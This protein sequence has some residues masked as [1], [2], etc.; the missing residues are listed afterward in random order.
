MKEN[1][2]L[3]ITLTK[4]KQKMIW[5]DKHFIALKCDFSAIILYHFLR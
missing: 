3:L 1:A 2:S 5:L 4:N